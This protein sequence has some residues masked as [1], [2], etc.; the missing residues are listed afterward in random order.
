[1]DRGD[2]L[3]LQGALMAAE[4]VENWLPGD[5][6]LY[7]PNI[8]GGCDFKATGSSRVVQLAVHLALDHDHWLQQE[9]YIH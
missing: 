3:Q 9:G 4:N 6:N 5:P 1:M 8:A 2:L 7:C